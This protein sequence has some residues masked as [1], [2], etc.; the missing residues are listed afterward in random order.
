MEINMEDVERK[1]FWKTVGDIFMFLVHFVTIIVPILGIGLADLYF[2]VMLITNDLPRIDIGIPVTFIRDFALLE[3]I[4]GA[5]WSFIARF[6]LRARWH[7]K[8]MK[9]QAILGTIVWLAQLAIGIVILI[10]SQGESLL[11]AGIYGGIAI[12]MLLDLYLVY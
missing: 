2:A 5:I 3:V 8:W 11:L 7:Y 1:G 6:R 4:V 12:G 10:S 9:A